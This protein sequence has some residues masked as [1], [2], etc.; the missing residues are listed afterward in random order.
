MRIFWKPQ[1]NDKISMCPISYVL[2]LIFKDIT[3]RQN[4]ESG[5]L[6]R[7]KTE[8]APGPV[9]TCFTTTPLTWEISRIAGLRFP[10]RRC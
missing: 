7:Q 4:C 3:L 8:H 9:P 6:E 2:K 1:I 5:I 10:P